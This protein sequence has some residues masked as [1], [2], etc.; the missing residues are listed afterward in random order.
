MVPAFDAYR[1]DVEPTELFKGDLESQGGLQGWQH[2][3]WQVFGVTA[4][5]FY[6][7]RLCRSAFGIDAAT[8]AKRVE[9]EVPFVQVLQLRNRQGVLMQ[10]VEQFV[11]VATLLPV[12]ARVMAAIRGERTVGAH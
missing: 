8:V 3:R 12:R 10:T 11:D 5:C 2:Y 9:G 4:A 6:D 7:D 1:A